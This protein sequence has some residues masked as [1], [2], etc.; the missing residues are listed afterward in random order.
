MRQLI[1]PLRFT[2][3]GPVSQY[4]AVNTLHDFHT[5]R[6]PQQYLDDPI[7]G[8]APATELHNALSHY[9]PG[10]VVEKP[11]VDLLRYHDQPEV[12]AQKIS[13]N[14]R[15][16]L[17]FMSRWRPRLD[18]ASAMIK[19]CQ[20]ERKAYYEGEHDPLVDHLGQPVPTG[21][22]LPPAEILEAMHQ[23]WNVRQIRRCRPLEKFI[24][25]TLGE[26]LNTN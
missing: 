21:V 14:S 25:T 23:T 16:V 24:G 17:D 18:L 9:N 3:K 5:L 4:Y 22:I 13:V 15:P 1:E 11:G 19:Y 2:V 7:F 8:V 10:D 12:I 6:Y 20:Q 26:T